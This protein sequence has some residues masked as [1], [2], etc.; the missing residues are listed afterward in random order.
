MIKSRAFFVSNDTVFKQFEYIIVELKLKWSAI[1]AVHTLKDVVCSKNMCL[2]FLYL[3]KS[4]R[5]VYLFSSFYIYQNHQE[6]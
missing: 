2:V 3:P 1:I 5:N 4:S 6:I